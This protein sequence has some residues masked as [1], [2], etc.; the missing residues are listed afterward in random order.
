[1]IEPILEYARKNGLDVESGFKPKDVRWA[2][3]CNSQGHFLE[4]VIELG[5]TENKRNK[6]RT[7][8]KCPDLSQS[9]L[10]ATNGPGCHFLVETAG[11]VALLSDGN[12]DERKAQKKHESFVNLL[13]LASTT[14]P[15]LLPVVSC[16]SD[17]ETLRKIQARLSEIGAKPADKVTVRIDERFPLDSNEWHQWW[18]DYRKAFRDSEAKPA[19]DLSKTRCFATGDL[20][21]PT[22]THP[23]IEG[24]SDVGGQSTGDVLVGFDKDSFQSYGFKKSENAAF[25]EESA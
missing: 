14:W 4:E 1:M 3:A 23:K 13:Q 18:R 20:V 2:I 10:I 6:G 22:R 7:F 21:K 15:S 16:L 9:E 8:A 12:T 17:E 24:L 5:D 11:V 25:S 19:D